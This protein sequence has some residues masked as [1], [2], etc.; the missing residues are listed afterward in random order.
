MPLI[1]RKVND[2]FRG[3][4]W[5]EL[6]PTRRPR[7]RPRQ[8]QP[9]PRAKKEHQPRLDLPPCRHCLARRANKHR[10]LCWTCYNLPAVREQ[11]PSE[12]KYARQG[13]GNVYRNAPLPAERTDACPGTEAKILAMI[14]RAARREQ[15]FRPD[16][17]PDNVIGDRPSGPMLVRR[18]ADGGLRGIYRSGSR[19]VVRWGA[20]I[21]GRTDTYAA[22][23]AM[24][25][26]HVTAR[27]A[28]VEARPA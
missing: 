9:K 28:T 11:Y 26:E 21:L 5:A 12:S 13:V 22:A 14:E 25:T 4:G 2:A 18:R 7:I 27:G 1:F 15:L 6:A 17:G 23:E 8:V 20:F 16:D 19:W 10:G 24:L 3:Q